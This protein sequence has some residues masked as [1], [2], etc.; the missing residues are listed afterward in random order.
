[1]KKTIIKLFVIIAIIIAIVAI[2]YINLAL[3]Q[4]K[5]EFKVATKWIP[6]T[7]LFVQSMICLIIFKQQETEP[8]LADTS[9]LLP[10]NVYRKR[11]IVHAIYLMV[12]YALCIIGDVILLFPGTTLYMIG[13]LF[14][15]GSYL[16]FG[17]SRVSG[18]HDYPRK[19]KVVLIVAISLAIFTGLLVVNLVGIITLIPSHDQSKNIPFI[20]GICIY[21]AVIVYALTMNCTYFLL[22]RTGTSL[23]SFIGTVL[24][25]VS[26][27]ILI[28]HDIIGNHLYLEIIAMS[29]Y[30]LGLTIISWSIY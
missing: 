15:I 14:F 12:A 19:R 4:D 27:V 22:Y 11:S 25:M 10:A 21:G 5:S 17:S 2:C 13:M 3:V 9:P 26:D 20:A 6:T 7:L 23:F 30:W 24:F 8:T 18:V 16:S 1:M 29:C 28:I